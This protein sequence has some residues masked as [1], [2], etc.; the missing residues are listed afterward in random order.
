MDVNDFSVRKDDT[1]R[2]KVTLAEAVTGCAAKLFFFN[3]VNDPND[4]GT[5]KKEWTS[6]VLQNG[7]SFPFDATGDQGYQI[8]LTATANDAA[9]L[10]SKVTF[11][12]GDPSGDDTVNLDPTTLN[13]LTW[14][15]NPKE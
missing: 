2:F 12:S 14:N 13:E 6:A 9:T 1:V 3:D 7:V 4:D 10:T 15:F 8:A 11:D 5:V